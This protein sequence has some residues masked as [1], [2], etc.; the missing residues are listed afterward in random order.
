MPAICKAAKA[1]IVA[2]IH[3][4]Y[5]RAIEAAEAEVRHLDAAI[6]KLRADREVLEGKLSEAKQRQQ[7]LILRGNTVKSRLHNALL[8]LKSSPR[9]LHYFGP[10]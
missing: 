3:F 4:H 6:S 5:R 10:D 9:T 7:G 1:P 2:D 8:Q